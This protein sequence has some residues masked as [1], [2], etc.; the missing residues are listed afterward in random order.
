M[1]SNRKRGRPPKTPLPEG[2]ERLSTAEITARYRQKMRESGKLQGT[3]WL[4]GKLIDQVKNL[5]SELGKTTSEVVEA[6]LAKEFKKK[7]NSMT[8]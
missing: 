6:I 7:N 8:P 4:D 2:S 5:S 3:Y 1:E